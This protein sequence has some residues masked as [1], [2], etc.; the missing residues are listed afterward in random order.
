MRVL[1]DRIF[2]E[3]KTSLA[4]ILKATKPIEGT[5]EQSMRSF[6]EILYFVQNDA[7]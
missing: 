1:Y 6:Q 7:S 4:V 2:G 5:P 3:M